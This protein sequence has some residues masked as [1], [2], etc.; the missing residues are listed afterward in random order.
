MSK[1]LRVGNG[2]YKILVKQGG[3]ITLDTTDNALDKT[4][5]VVVTG[6]LEIKGTTTTVDSTIVTIADN[7]IVL[8]KDNV[9]AGIP[10]SLNYRSG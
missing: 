2:D 5:T 4:G 10:A 3:S 1:I 9:A 6:N 7:I 8:S